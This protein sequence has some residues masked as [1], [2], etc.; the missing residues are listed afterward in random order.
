MGDR[1]A[2]IH[3]GLAERRRAAKV[4]RSERPAANANIFKGRRPWNRGFGAECGVMLSSKVHDFTRHGGIAWQ[5]SDYRKASRWKTRC[6]G[7]NVKSR[8]KTSLRK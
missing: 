8:P 7:L 2:Q 3:C 6:A 5:K 4:G 1:N